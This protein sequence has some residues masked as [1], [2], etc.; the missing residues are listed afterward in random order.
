MVITIGRE[1]GSGGRELGRKLAENLN[2]P[3][4]DLEIL[5]EIA[6]RTNLSENYIKQIVERRP[7]NSF[8]IHIGRSLHAVGITP[9]QDQNNLI[10][11]EQSETIKDLA[12]KSSCVI[13]GRC[14]DYIL[15]DYNIFR[16]FVYA[17][18]EHRIDRCI[19]RA[20]EDE[21]L[22]RA[23][24]KRKI[25]SIDKHRRKYYDF[26]TDAQWGKK[27]NYDLCINTTNISITDSARYLSEFIK[28]MGVLRQ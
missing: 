4:Y 21:K 25:N 14:A 1:F 26:Y 6:E 5:A 7:N 15:R 22:T 20:P 27:K 24:Y 19:E 8:P 23:E 10:Y 12:K 28:S 9:V 11:L 16:I 3:F 13:V 2:I 17:D 18:I